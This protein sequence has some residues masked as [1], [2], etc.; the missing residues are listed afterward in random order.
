MLA[1]TH[2]VFGSAAIFEVD[3]AQTY[4]KPIDFSV[5]SDHA[6]IVY[7][8]LPPNFRLKDLTED[9]DVVL[10]IYTRATG[11]E[12]SRVNLGSLWEESPFGLVPLVKV[13]PYRRGVVV[14][15]V[16]PGSGTFLAHVDNGG[17]VVVRRYFEGMYGAGLS[18]HRDFIVVSEAG[19]V[20]LLNDQLET[21]YTWTTPDTLLLFAQPVGNDILVLDG[22]RVEDPSGMHRLSGRLR[23]LTLEG[24]LSE[25]AS[26]A[27]PTTLFYY[28]APRLLVWPSQLSLFVHDGSQWQNCTLRHGEGEFACVVAGWQRDIRAL[29][30]VVAW[31]AYH[32]VVGSGDDGYIVA[33]PNGCAVWSRRYGLSDKV[34]RY[35]PSFPVGSSSL[36]IAK[37]LIIK[38]QEGALFALISS[39][40]TSGGDDRDH[41]T[42]FRSVDFLASALAEATREI[43]GCP[44]WSDIGFEHAVTAEEVRACV[45]K[46]ADPNAFG[47]CGAWTRP[48][49]MAARLADSDAVRALLEAGADPNAQDDDGDTALHDAAR[50]G[51]TPGKLEALLEGGANPMLLNNTGKLPWDY[52]R[53]NE[54]LGGSSALDKLRPDAE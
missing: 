51:K 4:A 35:Q 9:Q 24:R 53:E 46:G 43:D 45:D 37:D 50:Y 15:A 42:I 5:D 21:E 8:R 26:V 36:G 52:A 48:L 17:D 20:T 25:N 41:Q 49:S 16:R 3:D 44:G 27:L 18:Q 1:V 6:Y 40:R 32:N 34:S 33:V 54:A 10:G 29:P 7:Q 12:A 19:G 2:P 31:S 11:I 13:V 38:K 23:W 28:P 14:Q 39:D 22:E 47:N 30:E